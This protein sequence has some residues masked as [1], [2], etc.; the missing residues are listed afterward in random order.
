VVK[1][2]VTGGSLTRR[3]QR[4]LRCFTV[5]ARL[6][7]KVQNTTALTVKCVCR[8]NDLQQ[9]LLNKALLEL[10]ESLSE[11]HGKAFQQQF[12]QTKG[13]TPGKTPNLGV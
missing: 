1:L 8:N 11:S 12:S 4:S 2:V 3:P 9:N 10:S 5:K 7:L 6:Q 13:T